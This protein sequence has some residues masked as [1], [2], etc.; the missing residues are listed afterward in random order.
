MGQLKEGTDI[1]EGIGIEVYSNG[2]TLKLNH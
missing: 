2:H 1:Q